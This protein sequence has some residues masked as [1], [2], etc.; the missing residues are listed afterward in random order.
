MAKSLIKW[1]VDPEP[2]GQYRSFDKRSF[3]SADYNDGSERTCAWMHCK[4]DYSGRVVKTGHHD[5]ITVY[6]A[7]YRK[8]GKR[9]ICQTLNNNL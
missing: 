4:T 7:D 8:D 1:R 6:V 2:T 3:P 5:L 9:W